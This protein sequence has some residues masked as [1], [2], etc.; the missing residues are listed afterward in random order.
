MTYLEIVEAFNSL[1]TEMNEIQSRSGNIQEEMKR[2]QGLS[3]VEVAKEENLSVTQDVNGL[4]VSLDLDYKH[5]TTDI[6]TIN[7]LNF[8]VK[9]FNDINNFLG[10]YN[11]AILHHHD[12]VEEAE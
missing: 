11:E 4:E 5:L 7:G 9:T 3:V 2:L 10:P 12:K 1:R 6:I 8:S